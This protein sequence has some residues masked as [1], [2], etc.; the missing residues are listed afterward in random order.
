MVAVIEPGEQMQ[1][2]LGVTE[3]APVTADAWWVAALERETEGN[4]DT[5]WW[6]A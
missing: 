6:D 3:R 1:L 5:G 2:D 4:Q